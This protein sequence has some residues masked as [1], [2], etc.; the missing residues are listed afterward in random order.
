[1]SKLYLYRITDSFF[2]IKADNIAPDTANANR[3]GSKYT[4]MEKSVKSVTIEYDNSEIV[5]SKDIA[6]SSAS[7]SALVY[8]L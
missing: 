1:M 5:F 2:D 8:L 6:R 4:I 3:I 7:V